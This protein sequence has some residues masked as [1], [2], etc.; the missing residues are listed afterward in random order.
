MPVIVRIDYNRYEVE[1]EIHHPYCHLT[2][3]QYKN[4]RIPV[5]KPVSPMQFVTFILENFYYVP[6]KNF[7]EYDFKRYVL[8][9]E[10]HISESDLLK[11]HFKI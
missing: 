7:L 4:C 1:S 11:T 3:G 8:K 10:M 9:N 5:D 6:M 2:L